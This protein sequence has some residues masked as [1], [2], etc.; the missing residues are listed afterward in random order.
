MKV[1]VTGGAGYI[2][3]HTT[4][5]LLQ[6]GLDVVVLDNLWSEL[7][8]SNFTQKPINHAQKNKRTNKKK[9]T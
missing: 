8:Y 1:L 9:E 4:L 6:S 7:Q 3:S 5:A 2:G